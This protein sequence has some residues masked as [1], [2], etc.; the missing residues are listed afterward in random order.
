MILRLLVLLLLTFAIGYVGYRWIVGHSSQLTGF[1]SSF[2]LPIVF[3]IQIVFVICLSVPVLIKLRIYWLQRGDAAVVCS[4]GV[5]YYHDG[6]WSQAK[7]DEIA[8][9][10]ALRESV[11]KALMET[12]GGGGNVGAGELGLVLI[13]IGSIWTLLGGDSRNYALTTR[14]GDQIKL[15][16]T[17]SGIDDLIATIRDRTLSFQLVSAQQRLDAGAVMTFGPLAIDKASGLRCGEKGYTWEEIGT[18]SIEDEGTKI[19]KIKPRVGHQVKEIQV[20]ERD[21]P[22]VDLLLSLAAVQM[23]VAFD[24]GARSVGSPERPSGY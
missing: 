12:G 14:T 15:G 3:T 11:G 19:L 1:G 6:V 20:R 9:V 7:W 5:A 18:I 22:N 16:G 21:V 8:E 2:W 17:L 10:K 23:G 13:T 24:A 4:G